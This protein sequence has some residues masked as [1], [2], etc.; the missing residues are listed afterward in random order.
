M[1]KSTS[2]RTKAIESTRLF[3]LGNRLIARNRLTMSASA[4]TW[5]MSRLMFGAAQRDLAW[6]GTRGVD[7]VTE[8][9]LRHSVAGD[10]DHRRIGNDAN[11][12]KVVNRIVFG[13]LQSFGVTNTSPACANFVSGGEQQIVALRATAGMTFVSGQATLAASM[14]IPKLTLARIWFGWTPSL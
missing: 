2:L 14:S 13:G 4:S 9:F 12:G 6:I 11:L 7:Q 10:N 8:C 3:G 1:H 5:F